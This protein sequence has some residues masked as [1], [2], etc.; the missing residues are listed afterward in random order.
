M[1]TQKGEEISSVFSQRIKTLIGGDSVSSFARRVGLKQ[2]SVDRYVKAVHAPNAEA[3]MA[4]ATHCRVTADWL[5]GLSDNKDSKQEPLETGKLV[6]MIN[7]LPSTDS[8]SARR[9]GGACADCARKDLEIERLNRIV[10]NLSTAL[11]KK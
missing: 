1:S 3:L 11:A 10:D 2:A 5:L 6:D 9:D 7:V 4:I 8:G